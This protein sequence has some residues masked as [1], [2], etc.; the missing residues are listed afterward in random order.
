MTYLTI[1]KQLNLLEA[2]SAMTADQL[3]AELEKE[4]VGTLFANTKLF[5]SKQAPNNTLGNFFA[6]EHERLMQIAHFAADMQPER[7]WVLANLFLEIAG[8]TQT[9]L[10]IYQPDDGFLTKIAK[11]A[12]MEEAIE[13]IVKF[14]VGNSLFA[15]AEK[16]EALGKG[17]NGSEKDM[18]AAMTFFQNVHQVADSKPAVIA[19]S[20]RN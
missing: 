20:A 18:E 4:A 14:Y 1:K 15:W 6:E 5:Q 3:I 19:A 10:D 12:S 16:L 7:N 11:P 9:V 8:R 2:L 13:G 17:I